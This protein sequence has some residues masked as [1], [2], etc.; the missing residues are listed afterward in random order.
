M[1][2]QRQ[3]DGVGFM[4]LSWRLGPPLDALADLACMTE[5]AETRPTMPTYAATL[6]LDAVMVAA[7]SQKTVRA[8]LT[9]PV[10]APV[11]GKGC[12]YRALSCVAATS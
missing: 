7:Q 8:A 10:L 11:E 2:R 1:M 6:P 5:Y 3:A 4:F 12:L 9:E